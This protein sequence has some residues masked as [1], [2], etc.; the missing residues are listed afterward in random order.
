MVLVILYTCNQ[1]QII[2]TAASVHGFQVLWKIS[3]D[4]INIICVLS[5]CSVYVIYNNNQQTLFIS[6]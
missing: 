1:L 5:E 4:L 2:L 6:F 3:S